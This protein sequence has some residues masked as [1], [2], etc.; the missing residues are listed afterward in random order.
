MTAYEMCKTLIENY[1]RKG[2]LQREKEKLLQKMDVFLLGDRITE[3][4]Y[5]ELVQAMEVVA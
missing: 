1:K 3:K 4:Q 2:T 5:Q